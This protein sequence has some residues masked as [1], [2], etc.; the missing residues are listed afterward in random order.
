MNFTY[1]GGNTEK[2]LKYKSQYLPNYD[3]ESNTCKVDESETDAPE[4]AIEYN[5]YESMTWYQ[6]RLNEVSDSQAPIGL[7]AEFCEPGLSEKKVTLM[8][9][10]QYEHFMDSVNGDGGVAFDNTESTREGGTLEKLS[11][12]TGEML[13]LDTDDDA[14]NTHKAS[15]NDGCMSP[16]G[17]I[18]TGNVSSPM[19]LPAQLRASRHLLEKENLYMETE[20]Y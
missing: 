9:T 13:I 8:E 11:G 6:A 15:M 2:S 12:G 16:S 4:K 5:K 20:G 1:Y 14:V 18:H 17:D 3:A 19:M 7:H 10:G